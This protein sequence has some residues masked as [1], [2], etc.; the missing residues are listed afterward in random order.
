M[1][2]ARAPTARRAT[3]ARL[4]LAGLWLALAAGQPAQGCPF[5]DVV[6]ES[7]AMRRDAARA[8]AVGEASGP[9]MIGA[10]GFPAQTFRIAQALRGAVPAGERVVARVDGAV[11]G[12]AVLFGADRQGGLAWS[13]VAAN[14]AVLG[15]VAAAPA[16][17]VPPAERLRWF[18]ARL[19]HP[20]PAIAADAFTEFGLA[21]FAAVAEAA[22]AFDPSALAAWVK[23]PGIDDRR[24]GFYGLAAGLV[25]ARAEQPAVRES[26][27]TALEE[28]IRAPR[29]D[30]RAGFDGLLAGLFV[31][32]GGSALDTLTSLGLF[33]P[34]AR[35]MDQRH[36]LSALRFAGEHPAATMPRLTVAA[37]TARL[38]ASPAVAAD[39]AIDLARLE[40]WDHLDAVADLWGTL[41]RD[42]PLVR[43]AV[44]GY[45]AACPLPAARAR[46][47]RLREADPAR[48]AAALEAARSPLARP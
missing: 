15:H 27:R 38:L 42:D 34:L 41:G 7:L 8:V 13:A 29:T 3:G 46:L 17:V 48:L 47:D 9:A 14:E 45:L 33:A 2:D 30:F 28:A 6:G 44:A 22:D 25:A 1:R 23:E 19:E 24:R 35:A 32:D 20:E 16:L 12:T 11:E 43:R 39:A 37:A 10:D 31:V 36:L 26:L 18:A 21:P 40:A 4:C 5:C